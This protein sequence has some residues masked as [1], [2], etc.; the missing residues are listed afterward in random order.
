M[1]QSDTMTPDQQNKMMDALK[2]AGVVVPTGPDVQA[3]VKAA[4]SK[5]GVTIRPDWYVAVGSSYAIVGKSLQ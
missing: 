1:S 4:L 5:H 2:E 3:K